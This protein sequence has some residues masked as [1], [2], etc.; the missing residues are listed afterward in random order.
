MTHISDAQLYHLAMKIAAEADLTEEEAA[1]MEHIT[2]CN[3]CYHMIC[4]MMAMQEVTAHIGTLSLETACTADQAPIH[5]T[6]KTI[7]AAIHLAIHTA[8][9][10]LEQIEAGADN[11][12]FRSAPMALAGVRSIS[13]KPA[14][15]T[16]KIIDTANHQTFVAYD[17]AQK[18]LVVQI[19][20]ADRGTAPRAFVK[21]SDQMIEVEL[22]KRENLFWGQVRDLPEGEYE[23]LLEK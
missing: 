8:K 6:V 15:D 22:E 14:S 16:K 2:E 10:A 7:T 18:L 23:I 19:D 20:A 5:E 17:P 11:W 12:L 4:A 9:A 21:W 1:Y 13:K 3:D